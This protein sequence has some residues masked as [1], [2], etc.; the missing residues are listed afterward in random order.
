[1][2]DSLLLLNK[3]AD[4]DPCKGLIFRGHRTM[5]VKDGRIELKQGVRLLKRKSCKGCD[6]CE[7]WW[8]SL[9]EDVENEHIIFPEIEH[10]ALYSIRVVNESRDFETGY[11][12]DYDTEIYKL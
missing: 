4:E 11:V 8:D 9:N 7:W 3:V 2:T 12:D 5:F 1:M 6:K 10:G